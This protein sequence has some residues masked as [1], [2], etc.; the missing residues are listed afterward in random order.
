MAQ[1]ENHA[2]DFEA[3]DA[4]ENIGSNPPW[5]RYQLAYPVTR[6]RKPRCRFPVAL[7]A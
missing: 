2:D 3:F 4:I 7:P 5:R 6:R 1:P